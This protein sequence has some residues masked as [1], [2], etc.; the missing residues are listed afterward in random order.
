M[1]ILITGGAG[2]IGS[3]LCDFLIA[4]GDNIICYDNF[5]P[6][7]AEAVKRNNLK[8]VAG[9]QNFKLIEGDLTNYE[10]LSSVFT[11]HTFDMVVHLA[12][13]AGVRPSIMDPK[14][15]AAVNVTGT[16]NLLELMKIH[17]VKNLVFA[18]SSSIYGNNEKVPYSE[19]DN[20]DFPI[21]PYAATKKS[22][23]LFTYN[24]HHLYDLNVI[25]L[26]F[27]TVYGPRQRPDLAIHKFFK[28]I[29]NNSPI[30]VYG[31][32]STSRDYT[33]VDD[34][35]D[36][37]YAAMNYITAGNRIY[38]T[39]N[40][41]NSNPITLEGLIRAIETVTQKKFIINRLP[42]QQGDVNRT[43]ADISKAQSLLNYRPATKL[44]DGLEK[45]KVWFEYSNSKVY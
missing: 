44:L 31:D 14:A 34:I 24:Y 39:I 3:A 23:E 41:G 30:D 36:G 17:G 4:K 15:Y 40:L 38:E 33:Y 11:S 7:Y 13:K 27:F 22:G 35:V 45:F 25:N 9:N 10:K 43:F 18:S 5:D 21:S 20:V 29:Y 16:I 8:G 42:M 1:T 32:G 2:F 6:F 26:R 12:A 28:S 19:T 37:I